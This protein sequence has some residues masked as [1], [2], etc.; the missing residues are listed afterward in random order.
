MDPGVETAL[1]GL[2]TAVVG[3]GGTVYVAVLGFRNNKEALKNA[4]EGN[5][6]TLKATRA[7]QLA[8]RYTRAID[9]LGSATVDVTIGGIYALE[10]IA[11]D[12]RMTT[13][14]PSWKS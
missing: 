6:E 8:D 5:E 4:R 9:Q 12:S 13:T 7:G 3:V 10:R 1:I 2:A 14:T 11:R